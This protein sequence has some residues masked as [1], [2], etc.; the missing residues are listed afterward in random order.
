MVSDSGVGELLNMVKPLYALCSLI[1]TVIMPPFQGTFSL[2]AAKRVVT[3]LTSGMTAIPASCW[4]SVCT[5]QESTKDF[6]GGYGG[7]W[8]VLVDR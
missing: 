5:L 6:S 4:R 8:T 7:A 1:L 2:A 3:P